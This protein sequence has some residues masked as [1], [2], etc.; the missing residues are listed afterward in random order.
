MMYKFFHVS[1]WYFYH[2]QI[3]Q[4]LECQRDIDNFVG[5][6]QDLWALKLSEDKWAMI[7]QVTE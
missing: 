6:N 1:L 2:G 3:G 7:I 4:A 5:H